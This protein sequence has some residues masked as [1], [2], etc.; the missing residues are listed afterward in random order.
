MWQADE[1]NLTDAQQ[2]KLDDLRFQHQKMM[3]QKNADLK[4]AKLE[5]RNMMRKAEVDE[6]AVLEK[7]KRISALKSEIS[8]TRLKHR[9]EMRKV[10]TKDQLGKLN[11]LQRNRDRFKRFHRDGDRPRRM[12]RYYD[13]P[14]PGSGPGP[15][16]RSR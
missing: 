5:M 12:M 8:E 6:K 14:E 1:L 4:Q 9:L 10:L 11:K 13:C 7:Q 15:G 2:E 3:I 16:K